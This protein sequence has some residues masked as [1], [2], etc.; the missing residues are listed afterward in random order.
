MVGYY[1]VGTKAYGFLRDRDGDY[2]SI[3]APVSNP[4]VNTMVWGI[5]ASGDIVGQYVV[6]T[7]VRGFVLYRS[8]TP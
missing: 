3:E 6:G 8:R 4:A 2:E 1:M 5:N 7:I